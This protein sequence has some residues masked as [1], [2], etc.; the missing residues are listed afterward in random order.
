MLL[1]A[2]LLQQINTLHKDKIKER[3]TIISDYFF[4]NPNF[5]LFFLYEI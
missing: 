2:F 3:K 5:I 1:N 4:S